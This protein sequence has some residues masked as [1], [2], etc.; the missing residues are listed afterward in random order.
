M[1]K[2][3]RRQQD[4]DTVLLALPQ[5]LEE[6]YDRIL[7]SI[8]ESSKSDVRAVLQWLVFS[9][10]PLRLEEVAEIVAFDVPN[11]TFNVKRRLLNPLEVLTMCSSLLVLN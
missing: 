6:T 9:E 10:R 5:T 7:D 8:S 2:K 3:C 1:L 4:V 11:S